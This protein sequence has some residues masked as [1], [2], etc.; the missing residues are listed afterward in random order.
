MMDEMEYKDLVS[1]LKKELHDDFIL[2]KT[3]W[4]QMWFVASRYFLAYLV[5]FIIL[6]VIGL[7]VGVALDMG[8]TSM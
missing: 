3:M 4:Y 7:F 2:N 8:L 5:I 1:R 6:F